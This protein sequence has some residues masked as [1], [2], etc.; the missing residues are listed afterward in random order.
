VN[1]RK[2]ALG[3]TLAAA[4]LTIAGCQPGSAPAGRPRDAPGRF[5]AAETRGADG[6][7]LPGGPGLTATP[8]QYVT[9]RSAPLVAEIQTTGTVTPVVVSQVACQTSGVVSRVLHLA[10]DWVHKGEVV[11]RLDDAQ[12]KIAV[13]NAQAALENAKIN[14]AN[15]QDLAS[16][17][18]PKLALQVQA[19][20]AAVASAQKN[21]WSRPGPTCRKPSTSWTRTRNPQRAPWRSSSWP[22]TRRPTSSPRLSSTCNTPPSRPPSTASSPR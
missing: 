18:A 5:P 1:L 20:Q 14:L 22:S 11:V 16:Q 21:Y 19:A 9:V 8:V 7:G 13:Q 17:S 15:G 4:A 12:F 3:A 6:A 10:G 2:Y